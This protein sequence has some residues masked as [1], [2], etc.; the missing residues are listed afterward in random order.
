MFF[1]GSVPTK[2]HGGRSICCC[3][4]I[5]ISRK[6]WSSHCHILRPYR[7]K[8]VLFHS[9][10]SSNLGLYLDKCFDKIVKNAEAQPNKTVLTLFFPRIA[11]WHWWFTV[12]FFLFLVFRI[13]LGFFFLLFFS[14]FPSPLCLQNG[15]DAYKRRSLAHRLCKPL[16]RGIA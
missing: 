11:T 16:S 14:F 6:M 1:K 15:V 12:N 4:H 2:F 9:L 10:Q 3:H 13:F 8:C 7:I 5:R